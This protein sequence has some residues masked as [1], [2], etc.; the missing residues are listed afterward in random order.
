M[1]NEEITARKFENDRDNAE[2]RFLGNQQELKD[3]EK[4]IQNEKENLYKSTLSLF[5]GKC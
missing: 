1:A 2:S 4:N 3:L 5:K